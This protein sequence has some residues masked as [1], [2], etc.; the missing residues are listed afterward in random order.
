[1]RGARITAEQ[2]AILNA[3]GFSQTLEKGTTGMSWWDS[4]NW[5]EA[6]GKHLI[7]VDEFGCY[8]QGNA[9]I[10]T[11]SASSAYCCK[12]GQACQQSNWHTG[13]SKALWDGTAILPGKAEEVAKF[14][15]KLVALRK[16]FG[17]VFFWSSSSF[18]NTSPNA[19]Y[20]FYIGAG[21][22]YFSCNYARNGTGYYALCE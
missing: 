4:N 22:G 20:A 17:N 13:Q 7:A 16:L 12:Q 2:K 6:R 15:D 8:Y 3:A 14:S 21:S 10:Q 5:C 1:M 9:F 19:C 18:G 11:G